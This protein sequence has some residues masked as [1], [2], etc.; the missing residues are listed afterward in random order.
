MSDRVDPF[1][2]PTTDEI[3]AFDNESDHASAEHNWTVKL[4][5][6]EVAPRESTGLVNALR[7]ID[8]HDQDDGD[9]YDQDDGDRDACENCGEGYDKTRSWLR[10][11]GKNR[12]KTF[13]AKQH[14]G[15][16]SIPGIG[17]KQLENEVG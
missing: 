1:Q 9:E 17:G 13:H 12:R 14:T 11:Y 8:E 15:V 16:P 3:D 6:E 4:E 10:F 5:T 7:H 2:A